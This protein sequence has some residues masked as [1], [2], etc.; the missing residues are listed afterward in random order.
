MHG[1]GLTGTK[2][3]GTGLTGSIKLNENIHINN[4]QY[5]IYII[6]SILRRNK[7]NQ[8]CNSKT[9]TIFSPNIGKYF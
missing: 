9:P 7:K 4:Q 3:F 1:T 2:D 6:F 5:N 8:G